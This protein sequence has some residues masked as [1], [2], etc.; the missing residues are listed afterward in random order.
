[1]N[2]C[3]LIQNLRD[4]STWRCRLTYLSCD[5]NNLD[6]LQ[7]KFPRKSSLCL[8]LFTRIHK[9]EF[10]LSTKLVCLITFLCLLYMWFCQHSLVCWIICLVRWIVCHDWRLGECDCKLLSK[11]QTMKVWLE[12]LDHRRTK[13][14]SVFPPWF[15]LQF[16]QQCLSMPVTDHLMSHRAWSGMQIFKWVCLHMHNSLKYD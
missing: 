2:C 15:Q 13:A 4:I 12:E 6:Q 1:M 3:H 9:I 7:H 11:H 8:P 5:K 14:K 10:K 16:A